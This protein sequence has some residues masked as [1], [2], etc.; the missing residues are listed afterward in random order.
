MGEIGE[1]FRRRTW[2]K[3]EVRKRWSIKQGRKAQKFI[4]PHWWTSVIERMPNWTQ[5][6]KN[7]QVELY[8]EAIL[9]KMILVLMQFNRTRIISI[10]NDSSKS[11]GYH[12]QTARVRKTSSWRS[13]CWHPGKKGKML[14][15]Y[16]KFP[17]RNVQTFGFVY[18]D[19]KSQNHGPVWKTQSFLLSEICMVILWQDCYVKGNLSNVYSSTVGRRFPIG[20]AYS[21]TVRRVILICVCGW[22][23]IGR[24][25][26][27]HWSD[28]ES[29]Q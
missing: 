29:T 14:Q 4:L 17:N 12:L 27:K 2:R 13:V 23:Q 22:H 10:S 11:Q 15:N 26:T 25:E 5:S 20:N 24:K 19:T 3:S 7:T 16:W 1:R 28:V 8:S 18:H 6:T 21:Y 9:W